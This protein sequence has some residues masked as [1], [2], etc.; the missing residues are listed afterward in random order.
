LTDARQVV[1]FGRPK[2]SETE[3]QGEGEG[4]GDRDKE[5]ERHKGRRKKAMH[6]TQERKGSNTLTPSHTARNDTSIQQPNKQTNKIKNGRL[7]PL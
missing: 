7:L 1:Q 5:R 6:T 3:E 2:E 4:E